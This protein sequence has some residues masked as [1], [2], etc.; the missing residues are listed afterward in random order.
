VQRCASQQITVTQL[1]QT[2]QICDGVLA[3]INVKCSYGSKYICM[4]VT[5]ASQ[6]DKLK[7]P[8]SPMSILIAIHSA[9]AHDDPAP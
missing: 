1:S 2:S 4:E 5:S 8:Q 9:E 7:K 3:E 6:Q